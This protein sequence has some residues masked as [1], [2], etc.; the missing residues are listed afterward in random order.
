MGALTEAEARKRWCPFARMGDGVNRYL[1]V[2]VEEDG[3]PRIFPSNSYCVGSECMAWRH[4]KSG[5]PQEW[6]AR[7]AME[8]A[9][10]EIESRGFCG[11]AGK[12]A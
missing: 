9:P 6:I 11:L 1:A 2:G 8:G 7:A 12:P 10:L 4:E 3:R 5:I